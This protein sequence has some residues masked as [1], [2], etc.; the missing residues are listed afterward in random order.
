MKSS[1]ELTQ[2]IA[3]MKEVLRSDISE[4]E[5]LIRNGPTFGISSYAMD[6]GTKF[7][8][9]INEF[10]SIDYDQ[11]QKQVNQKYR[12]LGLCF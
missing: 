10:G 9:K 1:Y 4:E 7:I 3:V 12:S 8:L 11:L 5:E 6:P 2:R